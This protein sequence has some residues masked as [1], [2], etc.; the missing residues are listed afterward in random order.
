MLVPGAGVM[1]LVAIASLYVLTLPPSLPA[2]KTVLATWRPSEAW[3]YDRDGRL[4]DSER[5]DFRARRLAWLP[6]DRISPALVATVLKAEDHRFRYHDG[7][8]WAAFASALRG[9]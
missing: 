8:D 3:L 9:R 2:Y 4:I 6:L 7:V 5:V 1:L